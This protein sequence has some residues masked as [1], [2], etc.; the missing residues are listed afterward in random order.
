MN[1]R[2]CI[3]GSEIVNGFIHDTNSHFFA[4]ALYTLGYQVSEI[5]V[6]RDNPQQIK[7][8]WQRLAQDKD[9]ILH[10]G[11]LGPTSDDLTVDLM[12]EFLGCESKE[13]P[14]SL[15]KLKNFF[16]S[17]K[18]QEEIQKEA[19][20]SFDMA[21]R[22]IRY[23]EKSTVVENP[24][25]IA[26]GFFASSIPFIALPGFPLE[27]KGMWNDVV[28]IL[29]TLPLQKNY[30][31]Q[32]TLWGMGES[33]LFSRIK[34]PPTLEIGV[35][36]KPMGNSLFFR[37]P[38]QKFKQKN[39]SENTDAKSKI[40]IDKEVHNFL[41]TLKQEFPYSIG[42][43]PL[44]EFIEFLEK[45]NLTI[46]MAESCTAGLSAKVLTDFAGASAVFHGSVVS[47]ANNIKEKVI[48]VREKTIRKHGAVS[49]QTAL[50]M[51]AGVRKLMRADVAFSV[52]GIA[53]P[54]GGSIEKPV[55][56][57]FLGFSFS[58]TLRKK[59]ALPKM[60]YGQLYYPFGRERFRVI[61]VQTAYVLL[62][63]IFCK[64]KSFQ[65]WQ[66]SNFAKYFQAE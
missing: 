37:A 52:T 57:V 7:N 4:K 51:A 23:P 61:T 12:C 3:T 32:V 55:G 43:D 27:I 11:G 36:S 22:Q 6:I 9:L 38:L 5:T 41:N 26:P 45:E 13:H 42:Q 34:F 66:K 63:Q 18:A 19:A 14:A 25:G 39:N 35:H 21:R 30:T 46:T 15:K 8:T 60:L 49:K 31:K 56:T 47:Y 2:I 40:E 58:K 59:F 16:A 24:L 54:S 50:Q 44:K 33:D 65:D 64:A 10:S 20:L 29:E 28:K 53:G 62:W 48:G 1:I 17:K